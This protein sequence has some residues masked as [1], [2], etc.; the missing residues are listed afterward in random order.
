MKLTTLTSILAMKHKVIRAMVLLSAI[1]LLPSALFAQG[2]NTY[3]L[4]TEDNGTLEFLCTDNEY[5]EGASRSGYKINKVWSGDDVLNTPTAEAPGWSAVRK[6]I[7][8]VKFDESFANARPKSV[9]YW[10]DNSEN[11]ST[12]ANTLTKI[13]G[14]EYL[15]TSEVTSMS[16]TFFRCAVLESVDLGGFNT[17][18]VV[19]MSRM[20]MGCSALK[21]LDLSGFNTGSVANMNNMFAYC[22]ALA[23]LDLSGFDTKNV[24]DM[25]SMF[26]G[27]KNLSEINLGGFDT[28]SATTFANMFYGCA[29]IR[30]LDLTNFS[31]DNVTNAANM[32]ASCS[33]LATIRAAEDADWRNIANISNM[34]SGC[35]KLLAVS[36]DGTSCQYESGKNLPFVC[37]NGEG[38]FTSIAGY[39]ITYVGYNASDLAYQMVDKD[40]ATIKLKKNEFTDP[41][42]SKVFG[43]WN[44][45]KSGSGTSYNDGET[46][47][48]TSN[49]I[50][51]SQWGKDISLCDITINPQSYTFSGSECKPA[52][53]VE[54]NMETLTLDTDYNVAY[55]GNINSGTATITIRGIKNYA[56]SVDKTFTIKPANIGVAS[57][58][59]QRQVLAFSGEAQAPAYVLRNGDVRL[60][61]GVDYEISGLDGNSHVGDYTV[62]FTGK[63]NYTGI[64]TAIYTI[65]AQN[66]FAVWTEADATLTFLMAETA[67]KV[68]DD[69]NGNAVTAV[70]TGNDVLD[71]P[72]DGVPAWNSTV[73]EKVKVVNFDATFA[74]ASPK[75]IAY[76]FDNSINDNNNVSAGTLVQIKNIKNLNTSAVTSMQGAFNMCS[77]LSMI[78]VSKFNTDFVTDMSRMFQGCVSTSKIDVS[79]FYTESVVNMSRMF[80]GCRKVSNLATD[81]FDTKNVA[82][83]SYM[84]LDCATLTEVAVSGFNTEKVA[85]MHTMFGGCSS[86]KTIDVSNFVTSNVVSMGLDSM[87]AKCSSLTEINVSGFKTDKLESLSD[88]FSGCTKLTKVDVSG[89]NTENVQSMNFL[90][91]GCESLKSVDVSGFNIDKVW[92]IAGMFKDCKNLTKIDVSK[93]NTSNVIYFTWMFEGCSS[94]KDLDVKGFS[95]KSA[96]NLSSMFEGCASIKELNV[97][98]FDISE[99][100]LAERM[101]ANCSSLTTIR[102][103]EDTDWSAIPYQGELFDG[104]GVLVGV[105]AD[106]TSCKYDA[107]LNAPYICK[108]G[109][110]YFTPDNIYVITF[111]NNLDGTQLAYQVVAK[112]VEGKVKLA[113]NTFTSDVYD[114]VS[115]NTAADGTGVTSKDESEI[116]VGSDIT[117]YA[118]WGRDIALCEAYSSVEPYSY[119]YTGSNLY[120]AKNG[121]RII[122]KDGDKTL[123]S[124]VDYT[125]KYPD[126]NIDAGIYEIVVTGKG[127]YAGS[128]NLKYKIAPYDL[129]DVSIEPENAVYIYNGEAQCPDFVLTDGNGNTLQKDVD[130]KLLTD[131]SANIDGDEYMVELKGEGNYTGSN[132]AF[133]SIK[134]AFVVWTETNSTLTFVL[135]ENGYKEGVSYI[136][137]HKATKVWSGD[138]IAKSPVDGKPAWGEILGNLVTVNFKESFASVSPSSTAYWF[139]GA[140]KLKTIINPG[141][142]VTSEV[143]SMSNMFAGCKS[144]KGI[145]LSNF[146]TANVADMSKMFE[147]C[148]LVEELNVKTFNTAKATKMDGMFAN[149]T[150]LHTILANATDNWA[151]SNPSMSGMFAGDKA[152]VG[153]GTDNTF[154]KYVD[155]EDYPNVCRNGKGYF[156]A[157]NIHI[158]TFN[159]NNGGEQTFQS[160][161]S[162]SVV[163]VKLNANEFN[164]PGFL[165]VNWNTEPDGLGT[166]YDDEE[167]VRINENTTLYAMWKKDIAA[168]SYAFEPASS[169]FIGEEITP[170]LILTDGDYTLKENT[171][172]ILEG[173]S[174][175]I[176]AGNATASV[177]GRGEYAGKATFGFYIS[178]RNLKEVAVAVKSASTS[179]EYNKSAQAPEYALVFGTIQLVEGNDYT[180]SSIENNIEVGG[181]TVTFT[182]KGDYTGEASS[183]YEITP[184]DIA[185][186]TV[187]DIADQ[188]YNGSAIE[189]AIS[190]KDG[191][192]AL[193]ADK[194]YTVLFSNNVNAGTANVKVNGI[195]NYKGTIESATFKIAPLDLAKVEVSPKDAELPYNRG[196]QNPDFVLSANGVNL[197]VN[198]DYTVSGDLAKTDVADNYTVKF[199]AVEPGNFTGE[200]SVKYSITK[201]SLENYAEVVFEGGKTNFKFTGELIKP[202]VSIVDE[203]G[204]TLV[205]N[206]DYTLNNSGNTEI[207]SYNVT[208]TGIGNYTG[209]IT[210]NY[211]IV[212]KSL[213]D[214]TIEITDGP[215]VYD[216]TE[217]KPGVKVLNGETELIAGTDF[218]V[219]YNNNVNASDKA[220]VIL[221][222]LG[223]YE[224]SSNKALFTIEPRSIIDNVA[225]VLADDKELVYN[226]EA[227]LA[228]F[229]LKDGDIILTED[230]YTVGDY[231]KNIEAGIYVITFTGKGNY[232]GSISG[233]YE[234]KGCNIEDATVTTDELEKVYTGEAQ[235]V[236]LTV[237]IGEKQLVF[238]KDYTVSYEDALNVGT[239]TATVEG[240]GNYAGQSKN[241]VQFKIV[242]MPIADVTFEPKN[243]KW[244]VGYTGEP[245]F[246]AVVAKDKYGNTLEEG[247]DYAVDGYSNN[248]EVADGYTVVFTGK[249]NYTGTF[250]AAYKITE[251]SIE[252][253]EIV[254]VDGVE[255]YTYTGA[256]IKPVEKII[257]LG[258]TLVEGVDYIL[259]YNSNT[260]PGTAVISITGRG[261]YQGGQKI[262][263]FTIKKIEMED[264]AIVMSANSFEYNKTAQAPVFT[265][266]DKNGYTLVSGTDF[267]MTGADGNVNAAE[268]TVTFAAVEDGHYNGESAVKYT[269]TPVAVDIDKVTIKFSATEFTYNGEPQLP[270]ITVSYGDDVLKLVEDYEMGYGDNVNAGDVYVDV[271]GKNNYAGFQV[272]SDK[273]VINPCP[274]ADNMIQL[275]SGSS[276]EFIY[277]RHAQAPVLVVNGVGANVLVSGTDFEASSTAYN[278]DANDY[279][280]TF[281]GK[282]NYTGTAK[283]D[284]VIKPYDI[285]GDNS[286][287]EFKDGVSEFDYDGSRIT[288]EFTVTADGHTLEAETEYTVSGETSGINAKKYTIV[289]T[290]VGNYTNT[291]NASFR[292]KPRNIDGTAAIMFNDGDQYIETGSEIKPE[293]TVSDGA[294]DLADTDY[295]VAYS[296]N[297]TPGTATIEVTGI[298]N[299]DGFH[300]SVEFTILPK[301][302]VIVF[303]V[304]DGADVVYGSSKVAKDIKAQVADV[305]IGSITYNYADD[306]LLVPGKYTI[307]ATYTPAD[308]TSKAADAKV[309]VNVEKRALVINGVEVET[310]KTYDGNKT[311]KVTK[312]P[313]EI[314]NIVNGDEV[315]VTASAEYE[316]Q[317]TGKQKIVISYA[318]DG[319]DKDKYIAYNT[320]VDGEILKEEIKAT[321]NWV[322]ERQTAIDYMSSPEQSDHVHFC[323]GDKIE[324][325]CTATGMPLAYTIH[326][327]GDEK[328]NDIHGEYPG[329]GKAIEIEIPKG[330]K[331]GKYSISL[332]LENS[333]AET[334]SEPFTAEF[335]L[336]ASSDKDDENAI[337]KQKWDDVVYVANPHNEFVTYQWYRD[338]RPLTGETGQYYQ[339]KD[340]LV[341]VPYSVK[342]GKAD[343]GVVFSCPFAAT[344]SLKKSAEVAS[345][346]VYPNPAIAN[347]DFTVE[348]ENANIDGNITIMIYNGNGILT[349][350]KDNA[351]AISHLHLP[352]GQYT[353]VAMVDGKKLTF[354]VIVY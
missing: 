60:E 251:R 132:Y 36:I 260:E 86:A 123:I 207:G 278:V 342:I 290:G 244:S 68:G 30:E 59:P 152:L 197:T 95:T 14:I 334:Q 297:V 234:I 113:P 165:F 42:E 118:Q 333:D 259:S 33:A 159:D 266:T 240:T 151:K 209:T 97:G 274:L 343:G 257:D 298:G 233:N 10:F 188:E 31:A 208:A 76:W 336:D 4:W 19:D 11:G 325:S 299:Y 263:N 142:L 164:K 41:N 345:V 302:P 119:T 300:K 226:G 277:N 189:P 52:A 43:S 110:G 335:Y 199:T 55:T 16:N 92:S 1:V 222:G 78:N 351:S 102:A 268:Y 282:G 5:K 161:S 35:T 216:G 327:A 45:E 185:I 130:Y 181:Y 242:P 133:Y 291:Q 73:K 344:A 315:S 294:N 137:G 224:Y 21:E 309:T 32:F 217:K 314:N 255:E 18:K 149:C 171:D 247:K 273:F 237:K 202:V 162:V 47:E 239:A 93:F 232:T 243:G 225:A 96:T 44:T 348:I 34:F 39:M 20:F 353:G 326:V 145:D 83:M 173:Y 89:F 324:V 170:K 116:I 122:V 48:V 67:P 70:W 134:S 135:D 27:C 296:N 38:Y 7:K 245:I 172:Y 338:N 121:G 310:S 115:W 276:S 2:K 150:A 194:D 318:L 352:A 320:T 223:K 281:T 227:Q 174:N 264:V 280:I 316:T 155:G 347:Q 305:Y 289:I 230:D 214:A 321:V 267:T 71:S 166:A 203:Y 339:E 180:M 144:L 99:A 183:K 196:P 112:P 131:V 221:N 292:I 54:D 229:A 295:E 62:T 210:G 65:S 148:A 176:H 304:E 24:T 156:T 261:K 306:E 301:Q 279:T 192:D 109:K 126:D 211:R 205:E 275:S 332:V 160:V 346:K 85:N 312:Q 111:N 87:F 235:T 215:F 323:G 175:N 238:G 141:N 206:T 153:I 23:T 53:I 64:T 256:E 107:A 88:I 129:S 284:Y 77:S 139:A 90:F 46:I 262:A 37:N 350:R 61:E 287:V 13:E 213:E 120:V 201:L 272:R 246:P 22:S 231:S 124:D 100:K 186:A 179:L 319:K 84:F 253:V 283:F 303:N 9:A 57:I 125:I 167:E 79:G 270:E 146:N 29:S 117:L 241:T 286:V 26:Y 285:S 308:N 182:G 98:N 337:V 81:V 82:D 17:S 104:C 317:K 248:I 40:A 313:T 3:A 6:K 108:D 191:S 50:L 169:T 80:A 269:I 136:D 220:E 12:P 25:S 178:P 103:K 51:Y 94:L 147:G 200:T 250:T 265:L 258:K 177:R 311:A 74:E 322:M 195:G 252:D 219:E 106:G 340:G 212:D 127:I 15:N 218:T 190:V 329:D 168:C 63:G 249:G 331:Y 58:T 138:A 198:T 307:E 228:K 128:F 105:G 271:I 91:A 193:I 143:T 56:G 8:V 75:S 69:F 140:E 158:I 349:L 66:A 330:L 72:K 187:D 293:I 28:K 49:M 288:P 254:F 154:C 114:F 157:D 236:N 204:N 328:V 101:F 354:K 184:R 341:S 163:P